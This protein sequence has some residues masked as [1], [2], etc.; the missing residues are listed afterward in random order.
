MLRYTA[1]H[2]Y[3]PYV[4]APTIVSVQGVVPEAFVNLLDLV[5]GLACAGLLVY[6]V[7]ALLRAEDF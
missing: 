3:G 2:L 1:Q 5:A 7:Y 4:V 6:L